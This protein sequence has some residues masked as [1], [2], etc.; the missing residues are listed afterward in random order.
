MTRYR[1]HVV[2][3]DELIRDALSS[4]FSETY[5]VET[6]PSAESFLEAIPERPPDL[7]LLDLGLPG[8][9]GVDAL[10]VVKDRRPETVVVV[11]TAYEDAPRVISCMKAGA[12]DYI[13][14]PLDLE[15]LEITVRNALETIRLRK[16]VESLQ[17]KLLDEHIPAFIGKSDTI[18]SIM[19]L[20]ASVAKSPDT[21]VLIEGETG[22]GKEI[23]ASAIHYRSPN[24]Q[25]PLVT[26]N[27]AAI[28]KELLESEL[29]G[30]EKG[31]FTGASLSGK[32]G[33]V[34]MASGGTLFLDEVGEVNL[35]SQSKL[36]RFL[37]RGE[38][39]RVGGTKMHKVRTRV[40]A[41][42]NRDLL[43][44]VDAGHFR[45]DLYYR[46]AVVKL[47]VPSLN[48]RPGDIVPIALF[49][50]HEFSKKFGKKFTGISE[51]AR[52]ALK[53]F[54]WKGNVRELRNLVE[55]GALV[56]PGPEL[57][58]ADMGLAE[59]RREA[60][61]PAAGDG[62]GFP[63]IPPGGIDLPER[64]SAME[65]HYFSE[66]LAMAKGNETRA[67][68]LLGIPHHTFRYQRRKKEAKS[69]DV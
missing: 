2:D 21:P 31:A 53:A 17:A 59:I 66:A 62:T 32:V 52:E 18:Q 11:I 60:D 26:I 46:L 41:A 35:D 65:R 5:D 48:E 67:A 55:R 61:P 63:P 47:R 25:G 6:F 23:I 13:V 8:M 39:Y 3:D 16:E 36:L 43:K 58:S 14:K 64:I 69:P 49:F 51:E 10:K 12:Y 1:L 42:T 37:E 45:R 27:C 4:A 34:E 38:F 40:I 50:L 20:V 68:A 33:M 7:L 30:Y 22:T 15:T 56:G 19:E 9:S 24:F 28:P 57:G 44:E 29:F 54:R